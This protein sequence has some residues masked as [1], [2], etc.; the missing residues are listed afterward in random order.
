MKFKSEGAQGA[1]ERTCEK[2]MSPETDRGLRQS[3]IIT[4]IVRDRDSLCIPLPE[5]LWAHYEAS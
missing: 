2:E 1:Q 5:V 4:C 3:Y